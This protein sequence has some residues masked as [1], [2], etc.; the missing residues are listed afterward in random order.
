MNTNTNTEI[1]PFR[2]EIPQSDLDDLHDRLARTRW[3]APIPVPDP[4]TAGEW[5]KG[6]PLGY[7][8]DLA[9]HWQHTY[10]WRV[11]EAHLNEIPQ[12]TTVIDGQRIHF[13]HVRSPHADALPLILTH[14]W[15]G[16]I[17]EFLDLIGPLTDP[18]AHGG[19]AADAF[20]VVI[21]SL[22]GFGLSGP[23]SEP[24][25]TATR[26]GAAWAELM[27]RL[28]YERYGAQGGDVGAAVTPKVAAAAG[29][30]VIGIHLNGD[31]GLAPYP[32][33]DPD[34][35][36]TLNESEQARLAHIEQFMRDEYGYI[37]VQSTRPQTL[38]YGL[39]DSPVGQLAWII[40]KF[41]SWTLP[42]D[43]LPDKLIDR[44]RLLTNVMLY[45]LTATAGSSA[46]V[47]YAEAEWQSGGERGT[48]PTGVAVFAFDISIRRYAERAH[49]IVHWSEF[50]RG[51]HFAALEEPGLLT[52]DI[53]TFFR[54]LR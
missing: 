12:F 4:S 30:R 20:H 37:A 19:D 38:A 41:K 25:W 29:D 21:P 5:S 52:G 8:R 1:S 32:P 24:G 18:A 10:D 23:T 9:D 11:H 13:L 36:A 43:T 49:N 34:E 50:D 14:G 2:I 33:F 39:T 16:S 45:W 35:V 31:A 47:G 17:V 28:G 42:T 48:V 7:L 40:E 51:G 54:A 44:D 46:N 3:P 27:A 15:P 26:V 6:V 53:R 22:P